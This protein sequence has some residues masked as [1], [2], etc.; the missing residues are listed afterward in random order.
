[1]ARVSFLEGL[2]HPVKAFRVFTRSC[3]VRRAFVVYAVTGLA[4]CLAVS[5]LVAYVFSL[6]ASNVYYNGREVDSGLYV[7]DA[8]RDALVPADSA[9]WLVAQPGSWQEGSGSSEEKA[10]DEGSS[11]AGSPAASEVEAGE[12]GS[13]PIEMSIFVSRNESASRYQTLIPLDGSLAGTGDLLIEDVV[14][15]SA[16]SGPDARRALTVDLADIPAYDARHNKERGDVD[17]IRNALPA[18]VDGAKPVVSLVGYYVQGKTPVLYTAINVIGLLLVPLCCVACFLLTS[19]AFYRNVLSDPLRQMED[20]AG[21][22]AAG[23]LDFSLPAMVEGSKNELDALC[24]SFEVM[25][26]ELERANKSMWRAAENRRRVN[27]AFAHD[28]RTPLTVLKGRS[29]LL[30][31]LASSDSLDADSVASAAEAMQRQVIRLERYAESMRDLSALD[32]Y[33][34]EKSAVDLRR[35]FNRLADDMREYVEGAGL[36]L[37]PDVA[38]DLPDKVLIDEGALARIVEN[39]VSNAARYAA[40]QVGV[41]CSWETGFLIVAV[42]DDGPGFSGEAI[43][44]GREAFWRGDEPSAGGAANDEGACHFGLGLNIAASLCE[45]HGGELRLG[46]ASSAG[47]LVEARVGAP[48][49][50]S[51]S[52]ED[53]AARREFDGPDIEADS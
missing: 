30:S 11:S 29:E 39:A 18:A 42:E 2:R 50:E 9:D 24:S 23:D 43:E 5:F 6:I 4:A 8:G 38:G 51:A 21:R 33:R 41:R 40:T 19:R 44:R 22:I 52:D 25:R 13:V 45:K 16:V 28:L 15:T 31:A 46:A 49:A 14:A 37:S 1:M 34:I 26:A 7:Y 32:D 17:A 27:A 20:A 48:A 3:S 47:A 12:E 35:W 36:L 10:P 53:R